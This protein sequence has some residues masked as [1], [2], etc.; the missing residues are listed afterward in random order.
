MIAWMKNYLESS[1]RRGELL[2]EARALLAAMKHPAATCNI[3]DLM[4]LMLRIGVGVLLEAKQSID[5]A[6]VSLEMSKRIKEG[7]RPSYEE[8][9]LN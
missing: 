5:V 6:N 7:P 2:A 1:R 9:E 8:A 3:S 4:E